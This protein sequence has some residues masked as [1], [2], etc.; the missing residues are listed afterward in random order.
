MFLYHWLRKS[1]VTF[2]HILGDWGRILVVG[3]LILDSSARREENACFSWE[4]QKSF[5]IKGKKLFK[6]YKSTSNHVRTTIS[7]SISEEN[8]GKFSFESEWSYSIFSHFPLPLEKRCCLW[9]PLTLGKCCLGT[10]PHPLGNHWP[11]V[12]GVW[13]FSG[14]THSGC[15]ILQWPRQHCCYHIIII[16]LP[17]FAWNC[18]Q[19]WYHRTKLVN[20]YL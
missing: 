12:G 20:N 1:V 3:H 7:F 11:S 15:N 19:I 8:V 18:W 13:L 14:T 16:T 4:L 5:W 17:S 6:W 2:A 10:P 9:P